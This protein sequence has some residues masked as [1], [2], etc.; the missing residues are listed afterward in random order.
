ML[1]WFGSRVEINITIRNH[2]TSLVGGQL[3]LPNRDR[4]AL[5]TGQTSQAQLARTQQ[6]ISTPVIDWQA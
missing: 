4:K 5:M 3:L 1:V 6:L 2:V